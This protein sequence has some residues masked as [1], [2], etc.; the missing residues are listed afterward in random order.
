MESQN[1]T[2]GRMIEATVEFME[3][4]SGA[5]FHVGEFPQRR[6]GFIWQ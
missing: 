6:L 2:S 4:S 5:K 3:R 1:A